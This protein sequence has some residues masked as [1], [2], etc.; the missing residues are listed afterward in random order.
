MNIIDN[1]HPLFFDNSYQLK[2]LIECLTKKDWHID[3]IRQISFEVHKHTNS[4]IYVW[5][6]AEIISGGSIIDKRIYEVANRIKKMYGNNASIYNLLLAKLPAKQN[7]PAH[8][9]GGNLI[10]V[11]RCHYVIK[12][13]DKCIFKINDVD[14]KFK[15]GEAIEINNQLHHSVSNNGDEDRIHLICDILQN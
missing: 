11:R 1:Y 6:N 10:N 12:T 7:I 9:D 14:Y 15:E 13:N 2:D 4:I 8:R 3:T 5:Q